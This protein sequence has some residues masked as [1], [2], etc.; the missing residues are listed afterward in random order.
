MQDPGKLLWKLSLLTHQWTHLLLSENPEGLLGFAPET[1]L[2]MPGPRLETKLLFSG[3]LAESKSEQTVEF[4]L[5]WL[6]ITRLERDGHIVGAQE[7][8]I[9]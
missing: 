5:S 6:F 9:Q 7:I 8:F 3:W 2:T 1:I 4:F